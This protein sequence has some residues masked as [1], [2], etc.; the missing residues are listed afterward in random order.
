MVRSQINCIKVVR[1]DAAK[2]LVKILEFWLLP[3][4]VK[5]VVPAKFSRMPRLY[6]RRG[7]PVA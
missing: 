2:N 7:D 4:L 6:S 3:P 1:R 5:R